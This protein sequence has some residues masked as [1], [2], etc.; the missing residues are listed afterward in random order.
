MHE[1]L[2]DGRAF[3]LP[4]FPEVKVVRTFGVV[5]Y[6]TLNPLALY[7]DAGKPDIAP[8]RFAVLFVG[9]GD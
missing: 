1:S 4:T 6:R 7:L 9:H 8:L 3:T 2:K 5:L